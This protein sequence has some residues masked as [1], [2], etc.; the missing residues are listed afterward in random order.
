MI[1]SFLRASAS[2]G[3]GAARSNG[4][5]LRRRPMKRMCISSLALRV[6]RPGRARPVLIIALFLGAAAW[7]NGTI[8]ATASHFTNPGSTQYGMIGQQALPLDLT[9]HHGADAYRLGTGERSLCSTCRAAVQLSNMRAGL[10]LVLSGDDHLLFAAMPEFGDF[11]SGALVMLFFASTTQMSLCVPCL[12]LAPKKPAPDTET[13]TPDAR[14]SSSLTPS[15]QF[16]GLRCRRSAQPACC[17]R[18]T[19]RP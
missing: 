16:E 1:S 11:H 19:R 2:T 9:R 6:R 18:P 5:R 8:Q 4:L 10:E 13:I 17:R 7:S 14:C 3:A 12:R 15:A